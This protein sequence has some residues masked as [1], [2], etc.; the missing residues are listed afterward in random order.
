MS[1]GTR[2]RWALNNSAASACRP[3]AIKDPSR[4]NVGS[5]RSAAEA[6]IIPTNPP[7]TRPMIRQAASPI[8]AP[9]PATPPTAS[10]AKPSLT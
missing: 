8:A 9:T 6:V 7:P 5:P 4:E 3:L 1:V 2:S 10:S